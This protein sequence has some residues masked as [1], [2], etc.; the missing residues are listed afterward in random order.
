MGNLAR[1]IFKEI[2]SLPEEQQVEILDFIQFL[3]SKLRREEKLWNSFSLDS[4]MKGMEDEPLIYSEDD[5]KEHL[6]N[7]S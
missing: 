3:R 6:T 2:E 7:D 5:I 1:K 4:A